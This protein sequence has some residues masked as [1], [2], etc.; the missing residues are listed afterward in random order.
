MVMLSG[1]DAGTPTLTDVL[2]GDV[3]AVDAIR[4][5]RVGGLDLLPSD[6]RLAD[7]TAALQADGQMGRDLRLRVAL[8]SL[9]DRYAYC[10]VDSP[11]QM[12]ILGINILGACTDVIC[13]IDPGVFAQAG[14]S[15]LKDTIQRVRHYLQH[16]DLALIGVLLT[17]APQGKAA[18]ELLTRLRADHSELVFRTVIPQAVSVDAAHAAGRSIVE[19]APTSAVGKAYLDLVSEVLSH[20]QRK[21]ID[22]QAQPT[23]RTRRKRRA[24]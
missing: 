18:E 2:L 1:R 9:S 14:L 22:G 5:T 8:A 12:S 21:R 19:W 3:A 23:A 24:G 13:P 20:G 16:P 10:V 4:P 15:R 6:P 11:A 7:L 17:K